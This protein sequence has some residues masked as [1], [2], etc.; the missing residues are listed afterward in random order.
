MTT[1]ILQ[2]IFGMIMKDAKGSKAKESDANS[3]EQFIATSSEDLASIFSSA[4]FTPPSERRNSSLKY[5]ENIELD[6]GMCC[7][8]F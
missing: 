8:K 6:I 3:S 7:S 1:E 2:G 5:D 4:N